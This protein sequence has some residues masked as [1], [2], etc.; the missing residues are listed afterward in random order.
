MKV[1][2][3][4]ALMNNNRNNNTKFSTANNNTKKNLRPILYASCDKFMGEIAT[5][6]W[7][8]SKWVFNRN[9]T[10]EINKDIELAEYYETIYELQKKYKNWTTENVLKDVNEAL[11]HLFWY[12]NRKQNNQTKEEQ[13]DDY[14][15]AK[16]YLGFLLADMILRQ[17][18]EN[19]KCPDKFLRPEYIEYLRSVSIEEYVKHNAY[20]RW[21]ERNKD[22]YIKDSE[23][24]VSDYLHGVGFLDNTMINC[25]G[26]KCTQNI[27]AWSSIIGES[28]YKH[29]AT[30][31]KP[32]TKA[33]TYTLNRLNDKDDIQ[34]QIKD[35]KHF[36]NEFYPQ[37]LGW[38]MEGKEPDRVIINKIVDNMYGKSKVTNMFEFILKC[39]ILCHLKFKEHTQSRAKHGKRP[40]LLKAVPI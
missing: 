3:K 38:L 21:H 17:C 31:L 33:K 16:R 11:A 29:Y 37:V 39:S 25:K 6:V 36:V 14:Y 20:L 23:K 8:T 22:T 2:R 28:D 1:R 27:K 4:V 9:A 35:I 40:L 30:L 26:K 19:H 32:I 10:P 5:K 13:D 12:F 15:D 18:S 7:A 34:E 24:Q